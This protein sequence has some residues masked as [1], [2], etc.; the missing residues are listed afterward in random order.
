MAI[1]ANPE[2]IVLGVTG[3]VFLENKSINEAKKLF[4]KGPN[5]F[6]K[7]VSKDYELSFASKVT[8]TLSA[9]KYLISP[10]LIIWLVSFMVCVYMGEMN[11]PFKIIP[12][13]IV[14]FLCLMET[15]KY[16]LTYISLFKCLL[17]IILYLISIIIFILIVAFKMFLACFWVCF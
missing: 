16:K 14:Y 5:N 2:M 10:F 9:V 3:K 12:L 11:L 1:T 4:E 7:Q 6:I 15:L 17:K 13:I 8:K